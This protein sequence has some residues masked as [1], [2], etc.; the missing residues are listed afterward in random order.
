M[1]MN[2]PS[3]SAPDLPDEVRLRSAVLGA[4]RGQPLDKKSLA[5]ALGLDDAGKRVLRRLLQRMELD[6]ELIR[7]R[8]ERY[9]LPEDTDVI[10][11]TIQFRGNGSAYLLPS[12]VGDPELDIAAPDTATAMHGDRVA[13]RRELSSMAGP[14]RSSAR[15][16]RIIERKTETIVGTLQQSRAF[17]YVVA[18][19][20]RFVHNLYVKPPGG[21]DGAARV[22]DKVV[23]RLIGWESRHV[24]PEGEIVEVLGVPDDPAVETLAILRKYHLPVEFPA[25]VSA[26]AGRIEKQVG[27]SEDLRGRSEDLRGREDRRRNFVFT[28]DPD[29]ARDFDD[30]IEITALRGGGWELGV[31]IADVAHYVKPGSALDKEAQSRGNSTYLPEKVIPMLPEALSNGICSLRPDEDRLAFSVY[32]KFNAKGAVTAHRFAKSIIRSRAR[33]T[34]REAFALLSTNPDDE[35]STKVHEAWELASRLRSRRFDHGSLDL[36]FPEIKVRL[37]E[38]GYPVDMERIEND[39]SH[40]LIEEFMLFANETVARAL[41]SSRQP[42][43]YRIHEDPDTQRLEEFRE[44]VL[45]FGIRCGDL[46]HRQELQKVI[47]SIKGR[48]FEGAVK[49]ALLKSLKRARYAVEPV[50]HYGLHKKNYTHFTS[51]IRRY[52]DL[53]VHRSIERLIGWSKSGPDSRDLPSV[54][55]RISNTERNSA[56]AEREAVRIKKLDFFARQLKERTGRVFRA[57]VIELRNYGIF[58]ELPDCQFSGLIHLSAITDDFFRMDQGGKRLIGRGGRR[59]FAVGDLLDVVVVRVDRFKQQV[60]FAPAEKSSAAQGRPAQGRS[61]RGAPGRP[62]SRRRNSQKF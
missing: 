50:G 2:N 28:I 26:Q 9:A 37:D 57:Q 59:T 31:H 51:P 5:Q 27:R 46:T 17:Y 45:S 23:A 12:R 16:L 35:L 8:R 10:V 40:Q 43:I 39:A 24:N 36:D 60:D 33:L 55:E 34:Y 54:A 44:T 30:A 18:D 52:A 42:T 38:M 61:R 14:G 29:D 4:V 22:G 11:G 7:V 21:G 3:R 53:L 20:P 15:V 25:K 62:A 49:V 56:D 58:V 1:L 48:P 41:K 32:A 47:K 6:G 19:D 13:V